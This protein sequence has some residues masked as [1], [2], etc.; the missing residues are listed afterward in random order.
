MTAETIYGAILGTIL[1]LFIPLI[2]DWIKLAR[3]PLRPTQG[4][5][6]SKYQTNSTSQDWAN[7]EVEISYSFG[8]IKM[9]SIRNQLG[10]QWEGKAKIVDQR[11]LVGDLYSVKPG[12]RTLTS[13]I[14]VI[15]QQGGSLYGRWIKP[16]TKNIVITGRWVLGKKETD[17]EVARKRIS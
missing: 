10:H 7:E 6:F 1:S 16:S 5:W 4:K 8:R 3:S 2:W 12:A 9:K 17:V 11:Y 15:D 13:F 14:L